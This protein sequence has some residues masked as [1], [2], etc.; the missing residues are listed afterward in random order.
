LFERNYKRRPKVDGYAG[1]EQKVLGA[2]NGL[3]E[4]TFKIITSDGRNFE[5]LSP[6]WKTSVI[7]DL[8]LGGSEDTAALI[9]DQPEDNLATQYI[10]DGLLKAI[11]ACKEDRQIILVTHNATIP[12][13]GD[14]Q[15][16]VLCKNE[17]E[18]IMIRS[19]ALEGGVFNQR[20]VDHVATIT[21]G[22]KSAVKKRV[23]KYNIKSFVGDQ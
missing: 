12:M 23:K 2:F 7:L 17:G 19:D 9:I 10:N 3:N 22:G 16:V 8:I 21:D 20:V 14:A 1:L 5:D 6:G 18:K 4:K 11:Q 13:L 15:N